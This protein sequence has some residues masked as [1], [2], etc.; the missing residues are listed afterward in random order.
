LVTLPWNVI[1]F[2]T[3]GAPLT[4]S[5]IV[6]A[7]GVNATERATKKD[8]VA[9]VIAADVPVNVVPPSPESTQPPVATACV[10]AAAMGFPLT[11]LT[12]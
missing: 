7:N 1:D 12:E 10:R 9:A 11:S 4:E 3:H 5:A 8:P 6:Q 2:V